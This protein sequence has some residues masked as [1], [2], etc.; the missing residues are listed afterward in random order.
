ME[1][2]FGIFLSTA[3]ITGILAMILAVALLIYITIDI[4][5]NLKH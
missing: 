5:K 1:I 4:I 2:L 3:M